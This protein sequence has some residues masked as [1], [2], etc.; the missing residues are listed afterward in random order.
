MAITPVEVPLP[1]VVYLA[2]APGSPSF[3]APGDSV[4]VGDTLAM[5]EVM[6]SF[7]PVEAQVAGTFKGYVATNEA[8]VEPGDTLCEIEI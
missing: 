2:P 6:K 5:V 4:A 7:M 1:G 3:K 8:A